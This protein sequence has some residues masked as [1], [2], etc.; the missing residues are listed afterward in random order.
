VLALAAVAA[1]AAGATGKPDAP[2]A[3]CPL[4]EG[5]APPVCLDPAQAKYSP[6]FRG[7]TSGQVD[8]A[9]AAKVEADLAGGERR[10]EALSSLAYAYYVTSRR[11]AASPDVDPETAAR[12]ERWTTLLGDTFQASESDPRFQAALREAAGDL[13]RR[14]PAVSLSCTDAEGRVRECSSTAEL[15]ARMNDVRDQG[16]LRGRVAR[17]L[18]RWLGTG[19]P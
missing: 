2:G 10:Y 14:A 1:L 5:D 11:A 6:F 13:E 15:V 16:G 4:P 19:S 3:Y 17:L 18:E 7:L 8:P 9:A 12:L